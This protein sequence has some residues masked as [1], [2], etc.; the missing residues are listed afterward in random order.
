MVAGATGEKQYAVMLRLMEAE[1]RRL[2][3]PIPQKEAKRKE[4]AR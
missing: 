3:L 2:S 4:P 1:A